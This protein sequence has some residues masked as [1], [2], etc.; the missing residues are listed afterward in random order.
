M[1]PKRRQLK[2]EFRIIA[3]PVWIRH[4]G[5]VRAVNPRQPLDP[6]SYLCLPYT[7][8]LVRS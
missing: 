4:A 1:K 6:Y 3:F 2:I 5:P 7:S 8:K